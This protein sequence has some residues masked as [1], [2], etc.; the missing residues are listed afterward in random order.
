[1]NR[2]P[3]YQNHVATK[4]LSSKFVYSQVPSLQFVKKLIIAGTV[5]AKNPEVGSAT[6]HILFGRRP[7]FR[8]TFHHQEKEYRL[9]NL[10]LTSNKRHI[11]CDLDRLATSI[12]PFQLENHIPP[13]HTRKDQETSCTLNDCTPATPLNPLLFPYP[14]SDERFSLT[15]TFF[16]QKNSL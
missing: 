7:S 6:V 4:L 12:L 3:Y 16:H 5:K 1:M 10:T 11:P 9:I 14:V 2:Y 13:L 8:R 15:I